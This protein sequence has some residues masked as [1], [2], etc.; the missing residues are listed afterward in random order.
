ME[1]MLQKYPG[2]AVHR[3]CLEHVK[4][5][6]SSR[7][8]GEG[9]KAI[10]QMVGTEL[11]E[12]KYVS[13]WQRMLQKSQGA[14]AYL[15]DIPAEQWTLFADGGRRWG[16]TTTNTAESFNNVMKGCRH[17]PIR[18]LVES[19]LEKTVGIF[20][21]DLGRIGK[22]QTVLAPVPMRKFNKFRQRA[23]SHSVSCWNRDRKSVV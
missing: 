1:K 9:L 17:L 8:R 21:R 3:F 15:E 4:A 16:I 23:M 10:C 11:Q 22:C 19:T 18:A 12:D 13:A 6:M 2:A 14:H 20:Q 7:F 5:N